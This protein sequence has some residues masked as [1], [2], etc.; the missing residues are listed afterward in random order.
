MNLRPFGMGR[1]RGWSFVAL[2]VV[3]LV[4]GWGIVA[5]LR[6]PA[7]G[8]LPSIRIGEAGTVELALLY[9]ADGMGF[10]EDEGVDVELV[11][12]PSGRDAM[13]A[14]LAGEVDLATPY[15]GPV[16]LNA[17][18]DEPI[19]VLTVLAFAPDNTRLLI[20]ASSG[21]DDPAG[22]RGKRVGI[23]DNSNPVYL[24]SLL[25]RESGMD[26]ADLET[27]PMS[28]PETVTAIIDGDVDAIAIWS[29]YWQQVR[30]ALGA[31]AIATYTSPIYVESAFLATTPVVLEQR[32]DVIQS[33]LRALIRAEVHQNANPE[34][35][36]G[37]LVTRLSD[38]MSEAIVREQ[39]GTVEF[40]IRLD[41]R[42]AVSLESQAE[43]FAEVAGIGDVPD[44]FS[45]ILAPGPLR[46]VAP[47]RVTYGA[48]GP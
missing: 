40:A 26:L 38:K 24:L 6:T 32:G 14:A 10:F 22:L 3:V 45:V 8:A 17:N 21:I 7:Q 46:S 20:R 41:Q 30:D 36:L 2:A 39:W 43:W 19:R 1:A 9:I 29:P 27:V 13:A 47:I 28:P 11:R 33:V 12:Y 35:A 48:G 37:L 25:L 16:V 42:T 15:D 31:D 18:R 5:S 44:D 23:V 34:E 4:A